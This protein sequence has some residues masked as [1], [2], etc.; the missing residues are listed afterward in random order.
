MSAPCHATSGEKIRS[1]SGLNRRC[2]HVHVAQCYCGP[3]CLTSSR[4]NRFQTAS[5]L[6]P[7]LIGC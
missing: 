7:E 5:R 1:D 3:S 2:P 4:A 6:L